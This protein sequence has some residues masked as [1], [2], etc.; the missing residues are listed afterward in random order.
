MESIIAAALVLAAGAGGAW[1]ARARGIW[2]FSPG[3]RDA[4]VDGRAGAVAGVVVDGPPM[5]AAPLTGAPCVYWQLSFDEVGAHDWIER[6]R[7]SARGEFMLDVEGGSVRVIAEAGAQLDVPVHRVERRPVFDVRIDSTDLI[8]QQ[9]RAAGVRFAYPYSTLRVTERIVAPGM[10]VKV[11]GWCAREPDPGGV[12]DVSGYR[13][14]LP[15]R[16]V[17]SGTRRAPLL[18]ATT[19]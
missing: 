13:E 9:A 5:I 3:P 17:L 16:P 18:I 6:A 8:Q 11:Y 15:T 2:G 10:H 14:A 7:V 4:L 12:A 19:S 1:V